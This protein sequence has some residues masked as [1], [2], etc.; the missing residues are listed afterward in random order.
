LCWELELVLC[1]EF[2]FV[3]EFQS[4]FVEVEI[5]QKAVAEPDPLEVVG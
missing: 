1:W 4:T 3:V 2:E 5:A